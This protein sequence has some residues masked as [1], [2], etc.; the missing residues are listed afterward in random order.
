MYCQ[1]LSITPRGDKPTRL[2]KQI[3]Q[4]EN[5]KILLPEDAH[6]LSSFEAELLGFPGGRHDDQVDSVSQFLNH[7]GQRDGRIRYAPDGTKLR[8]NPKRQSSGRGKKYI[9]T[10][11]APVALF[12]TSELD[13]MKY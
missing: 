8:P 11:T 12:G 9:G 7:V 6:W 10:K 3:Y 2:L 5:S 4:I 1:V 13:V